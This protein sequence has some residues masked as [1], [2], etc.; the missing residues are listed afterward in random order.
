[1]GAREGAERPTG[2]FNIFSAIS[3]RLEVIVKPLRGFTTPPNRANSTN[4]GQVLLH[5][6]HHLSL[7]SFQQVFHLLSMKLH[8]IYTFPSNISAHYVGANIIA[9]AAKEAKLL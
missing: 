5:P 3:A 1:M 2:R 7:K 4:V 9:N 6:F 8:F